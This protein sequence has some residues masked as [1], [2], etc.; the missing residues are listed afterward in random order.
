MSRALAY[1]DRAWRWWRVLYLVLAVGAVGGI[2][3]A[4][5]AQ[6]RKDRQFVEAKLLPLA[7]FVTAFRDANGHLPTQAEFAGWA[8]RTDGNAK[9]EY[10]PQKPDFVADWGTPGH[11][12]LVGSWRGQWM[13]YYQSWNGKD[14]AGEMAA[15]REP[16]PAH[17]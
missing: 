14:F 12:F 5:A 6:A 3:L 13:H 15:S 7:G 2:V 8:D 10:Y 16:S 17:H 4:A 9:V 11:D 1:F